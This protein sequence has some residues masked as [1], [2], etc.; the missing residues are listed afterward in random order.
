MVPWTWL[1]GTKDQQVSEGGTSPPGCYQH[2]E[3]HSLWQSHSLHDLSQEAALQ[4]HSL[5]TRLL[6][7]GGLLKFQQQFLSIQVI[8][9]KCKAVK[10][11]ERHLYIYLGKNKAKSWLWHQIKCLETLTKKNT[12]PF[13][14]PADNRQSHTLQC[15][16]AHSI[17]HSSNTT[18]LPYFASA[19]P[20]HPHRQRSAG[21]PSIPSY[22]LRF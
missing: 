22:K 2:R 9:L 4:N 6:Q 21:G 20:V 13:S 7:R 16:A 10:A 15:I 14:V 17:Q 3:L 11:V 18:I 8:F 12:L 5:E 1:E 19:A